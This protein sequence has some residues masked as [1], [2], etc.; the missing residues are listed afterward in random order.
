MS[1]LSK[2][3]N[4]QDIEGK[5]Y[6]YWNE[7]GYFHS[8]PDNREAYSIVIPP[9]NVTGILHMGHMLNNTIQD[10]LIRRARL[11]GKNACWVPGTDHASIATEAK[12]VKWL[13]EEKGLKKS[14]LSR[15]EFMKY[16]WEW[17]EKYGG[18]ILNQLQRLG[19]SCD[20]QRTAFTMDDVRSK[21]VIKAFV[22]LYNRGK[23]YRGLRMI[24]WDPQAQT[25]LSNEEVIY[26]E[27]NARLYKLRYVRTDDPGKALDISTQRPETIMADTAIAVHPDDERY[28]DWVGKKV[29]IPLINKEIPVI[30]DDYV[31]IEFGT[32][33]LKVTPAHDINDYELGKKHN[34]EI[35]DILNDDGTLNEK[36]TILIGQDRFEAR[37]NI[38]TLLEEAC[39]LEGTID[40]RTNI[41]RSERTNAVVEPKLSLQ[42][43]VDMKALAG[44]ALKAVNDG[45]IN[46]YPKNQVNTYNHWLENIRDWCISRQL[47]WGHRIPAYYYADDV[48]V[49]ARREEAESLA[50][51]KIGADFDAAKLRQ[52]EDALDTWFSS[53]LWPITVFD[54]FSD[55]KDYGYYVPT[56]VLV[57][58]WDI[59]FLWV[60]R[61]IMAGYEWKEERPFKDVYF[62]G[63]VRDKQRRKMSKSLGNSPDA[64]GLI[65]MYGAD[66]VRFGMMSS[67]PAG[68]DLLFDE[69]LCEQGRNFCNK[70]WNALRLITSWEVSDTSDA[71]VRNKNKLACDFMR[72]RISEVQTQ[73]EANFDAYRLSENLILIYSLIWDD[74][75]AYYLEMIKPT[76]GQPVDRET[77]VEANALFADLM[78]I[79]HPFMPFIS[80]EVYQQVK[81]KDMPDCI[82]ARYPTPAFKNDVMVEGFAFFKDFVSLIRDI[83]NRNGLKQRDILPV[84]P[85]GDISSYLSLSGYRELMES[86]AY[87]ELR[88]EDNLDAERSVTSLLRTV[89]I[90]VELPHVAGNKAEAQA[91]ILEKIKY[92]EGFVASIN[93]KLE[94]QRF[95]EN[96]PAEVIE[97]ERKKLADS[98]ASIEALKKELK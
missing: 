21:G 89:K 55:G 70:I 74:F 75:C 90:F 60:A 29:L 76:Y 32:G 87:V 98:L 64:L 6:A 12:V 23:I 40:Y 52:D 62:T 34:L 69:K 9:P 33:A 48:F 71:S 5:W 86:I 73:T 91:E 8:E 66:G 7:K 11:M 30:A 39:L 45:D 3:Y 4:P 17:T 59:I 94:N 92:F 58:G 77:L 44:P 37:K 68:G 79:L 97:K 63:M 25:V 18:I 49:A 54:G 38:I 43:F 51:A 57:T 28:R 56:S 19:A 61:M 2:T 15:D 1:Q 53:W 80:E 96:A 20:W 93:K 35:I 85:E 31:D 13:R 16:A 14:D 10:I 41:G 78:I 27:E 83:R 82:V 72:Q 36:A 95:V 65:D 67:S 84:Y 22:D 50:K 24:N 81:M 26:G 42:W 47:W 46:F 88:S